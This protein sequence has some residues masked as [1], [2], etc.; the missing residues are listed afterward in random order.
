VDSSEKRIAAN[1]MNAAKSTGPQ[2]PDGKV[3]VSQN[4]FK[5][6]LRGE[7]H[8]IAGED[9][10][11][12]EQS[13]WRL[14]EQ[15]SPQG[16]LESEFAERVVS[17]F[18]RL[19]R[20]ERIEVELFDRMCQV[21]LETR[22]K[23]VARDRSISVITFAQSELSAVAGR[24]PECDAPP[25][26]EIPPEVSLGSAIHTQLCYNDSI[27]KFHRYEAHIERGLFKALHE[28]QRLQAIRRGI[29]VPA[30]I[31]IDITTDQKTES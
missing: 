14:L 16:A 26:P 15:L 29:P 30:P 3:R 10:A 22:Q 2:T 4:A 8:L 17:S 11:E 5:H 12:Y 28:L 19:R 7:F 27:G 23:R 24:P 6:G 1:R 9:A 21:D 13:R 25:E 20:I 18:W 31:A